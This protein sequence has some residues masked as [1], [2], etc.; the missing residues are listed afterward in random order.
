[1]FS[2][3]ILDGQ[4]FFCRILRWIVQEREADT[5]FALHFLFLF[6]FVKKSISKKCS[7]LK[8]VT[9]LRNLLQAPLKYVFNFFLIKNTLKVEV[10]YTNI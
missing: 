2:R 3:N 5:P 1:M 6:H 4:G 9:H 7:N 8:L 10:Y